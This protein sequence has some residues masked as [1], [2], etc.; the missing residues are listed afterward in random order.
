MSHS[1]DRAPS[2]APSV[3]AEAV[4]ETEVEQPL[5]GGKK[6]VSAKELMEATGGSG[7]QWVQRRGV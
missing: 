2:P 7:D 4:Q 1:S 6:K 5:L 3:G